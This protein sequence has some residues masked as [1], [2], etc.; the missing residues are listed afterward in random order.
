MKTFEELAVEMPLPDGFEWFAVERYK[1]QKK[2]YGIKS[3]G[4]WHFGIQ[5]D[6]TMFAHCPGGD[7]KT[8]REKSTGDM[9]SD[10]RLMHGWFLMGMY[11]L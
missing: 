4:W 6:M 8:M 9:E 7:Q 3:G 5:E 1:E 10:M 2:G 11:S